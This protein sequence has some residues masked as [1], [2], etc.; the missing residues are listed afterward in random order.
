VKELGARAARLRR[1]ITVPSIALGIVGS[2]L[3]YLLVRE[4]QFALW[5]GQLVWLSGIAGG[6]PPFAASFRVARKLGDAAV[7]KRKPAWVD[8]MV[9]THKLPAGVLDEY[10]TVL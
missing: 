10:L 1:R 2:V 9:R 5:N 6:L 8:E 4:I 7:A 3:G